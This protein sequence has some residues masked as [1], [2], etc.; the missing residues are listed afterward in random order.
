ME[1]NR[2]LSLDAELVSFFSIENILTR[3]IYHH[4]FFFNLETY[5]GKGKPNNSASTTLN[6]RMSLFISLSSLYFPHI[7]SETDRWTS[8]DTDVDPT[9][10]QPVAPISNYR[11]KR[12]INL[13]AR[14]MPIWD[15]CWEK[16]HE[17]VYNT[18]S[19]LLNSTRTVI[20]MFIEL[21]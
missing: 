10:T 4:Q 19:S 17:H 2:T 6:Y 16:N 1:R 18:S 5:W 14:D 20:E 3:K 11:N 12:L 7:L 15:F 21:K 9:W 13:R 8:N